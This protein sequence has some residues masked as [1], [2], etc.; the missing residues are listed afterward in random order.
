MTLEELKE[1]VKDKGREMKNA[2]GYI[3]RC[4]KPF[5]EC[6]VCQALA[7]TIVHRVKEDE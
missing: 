3:G 2:L 7:D 4:G 1:A 5:E 6:N